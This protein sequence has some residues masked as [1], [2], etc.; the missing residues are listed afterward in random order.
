MLTFLRTLP[1]T[2]WRVTLAFAGL[3][4]VTQIAI[5]VARSGS[6]SVMQLLVEFVLTLVLLAVPVWIAWRGRQQRSLWY[7]VGALVLLAT[8]WKIF[9]F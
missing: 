9:F 7:A 5:G 2:I 8:M 6:V 1:D 4:I 3:A